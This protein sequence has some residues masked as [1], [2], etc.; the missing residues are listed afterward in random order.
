MARRPHQRVL[1]PF[2][3]QP[4]ATVREWRLS[5]FMS[6]GPFSIRVIIW[7]T[8]CLRTPKLAQGTFT[9]GTHTHAG[10]T[11]EGEPERD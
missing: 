7:Y 9:H 11:Q 2:C 8:D 4:A 5:G 10:R 6:S 3:T 1:T